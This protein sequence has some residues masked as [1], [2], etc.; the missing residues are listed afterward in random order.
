MSLSSVLVCSIINTTIY[1]MLSLLAFLLLNILI[2]LV[3]QRKTNSEPVDWDQNVT[4]FLLSLEGA[5][6]ILCCVPFSFYIAQCVLNG[7]NVLDPSY[8]I[9]K[10][11]NNDLKE[12]MGW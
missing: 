6:C 10:I 4:L 11:Q 5:L 2:I 3:Y 8:M 7:G 1:K 12:N 9:L